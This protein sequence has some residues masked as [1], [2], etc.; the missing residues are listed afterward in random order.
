MAQQVVEQELEV[1]LRVFELGVEHFF[2]VVFDMI[3]LLLL[4]WFGFGRCSISEKFL[5]K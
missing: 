1:F 2:A 4:C 3:V 5:G